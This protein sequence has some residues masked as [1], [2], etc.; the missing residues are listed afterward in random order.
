MKTA[1]S[2]PDELFHQV[3]ALA[4]RLGIPRSQ[5]YARALTEYLA[6]HGPEHVTASLDAVYSDVDSS[7]DPVIVAAQAASVRKDEWG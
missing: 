7:L 1:I 5:L 2:L 6:A 3:D 4:E